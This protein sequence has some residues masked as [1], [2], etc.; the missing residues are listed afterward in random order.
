MFGIFAGSMTKAIICTVVDD[1][2]VDRLIEEWANCFRRTC[3]AARVFIRMLNRAVSACS[4]NNNNNTTATEQVVALGK[5]GELMS[6]C[7]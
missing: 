3:M 7:S 1:F 4:N 2:S 6:E 5:A